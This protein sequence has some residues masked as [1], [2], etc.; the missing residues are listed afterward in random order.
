MLGKRMP[1]QTVRTC[2]RAVA[3]SA[4]LRVGQDAFALQSYMHR[5]LLSV[6]AATNLVFPQCWA[7]VTLVA[8]TMVLAGCWHM[9]KAPVMCTRTCGGC[10]LD[11]L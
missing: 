8:E 10:T 4:W 5:C 3:Y 2:D 1:E 6:A 7:C 11:P 9:M